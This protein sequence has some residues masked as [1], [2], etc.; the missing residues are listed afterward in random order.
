M[1]RL[2]SILE[3]GLKFTVQ[4]KTKQSVAP[5]EPT[6]GNTSAA[7]PPPATNT[8]QQRGRWKMNKTASESKLHSHFMLSPREECIQLR[9][10]SSTQPD[11]KNSSKDRNV[12]EVVYSNTPVQ[13]SQWDVLCPAVDD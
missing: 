4:T 9:N 6:A 7:T 11:S 3:N 5:A 12:E 1:E 10:P 13:I 2:T 8:E